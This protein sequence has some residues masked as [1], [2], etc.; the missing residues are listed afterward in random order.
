MKHTF[1]YLI[2]L[3]GL[4]STFL[5]TACAVN[6]VTGKKQ[7]S[8]TSESQEIE[9]GKSYHPQVMAEFGKFDHPQLQA[10]LNSKGQAMAAKSHRP[11]LPW[12]FE[13][14]DSPVVNAFAVP[15]GY[16]YFTRGIMAHFNNEA[17][18]AGVL[19]HEIGHVTARHS[20]QQQT[21]QTLA[22]GGLI[23]GMI[24]S[25]EMASMGE[26]LMQGMG[27]L[28]MKFSRDAESQSDELGVEYSTLIGY[29]AQ[30]MA[31]FFS[32][33]NRLSGGPEGRVPTFMSTHP[34]PADRQERVGQ[35]ARAKQQQLAQQGITKF[36]VGRDSYLRML[37]GLLYGED[38]RQGFVEASTFYHPELKFQ[39]ALPNGWQT[40]NTP[41]AVI[42]GEP[43]GKAVLQLRLAQGSDP[44]AAAQQFAQENKLQVIGSRQQNINGFPAVIM[45]AQ[46]T[47]DPQAQQQGQQQP[48]IG[49]KA[50]FISYQG[51]VYMLFGLAAQTD[52]ARYEL[53]FDN[54]IAS[55]RQLTDPAKLN[56]QPERLR[57]ATVKSNSNLQ[58]ALQ[59]E[60]IPQNR[61]QEFSVLN[62]MELNAQL[63]AGTLIKVLK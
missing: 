29:D 44:M 13:L 53:T 52:F 14:V 40:Q 25:P 16:V 58:A 56:K 5:F 34:D 20:V 63:A 8:L 50:G 62:G 26:S 30:E 6:P 54:S 10:F 17:Q 2:G 57:I 47:P 61:M 12:N 32:T 38:P 4:A 11:N 33:L 59:A 60:G 43:N 37:E 35:M 7:V 24:L 22:M 45:Q 18:F 9:M 41:Q 48:I 21:K 23:T 42:S 49:I 28:F 55:F 19:G 27:L 31:G 36:D 46:T 15:G 3:L 39:Y 51:N 1:L